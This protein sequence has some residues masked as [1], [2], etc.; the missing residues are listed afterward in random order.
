[1]CYSP[2]RYAWDLQEQYLK[3]T[4]LN[5]GIRG[6]VVRSI[7]NRIRIW[8][9]NTV[10][11]VNH[12]I[13]ISEY[14]SKRIKK[15]YM[16][17]STV[18]YPPVDTEKFSLSK[19]I[20]KEYYVTCSRM[21][22]YK[23]IDL[24]VETFTKKFPDKK[25][26]VVGDGPDYKKIK[27]LAG[28]NILF[29][30][31]ANFRVLNKHLCHAKAFVFAAEEDF[32]ISPIEAQSCGTPVIAFGKGGAKETV[33]G[34]D[35]KNPTGVF[36]NEQTI[37]S[38]SKAIHIFEENIGKITRESCRKNALRFNKERFRCE[39]RDFVESKLTSKLKK[40]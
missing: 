21:V 17:D 11:S 33:R 12:F 18:I 2:I 8:D 3:E 26:I 35:Q 19:C 9:L 37:D 30:G 13:A 14:I 40:I 4:K 29:E 20:K 24:I 32:G 16:R 6:L 36:F 22:P 23:K 28:L 10:K 34:L 38:L 5:K 31:R 7:L 1:M 25:L 39:F 15:T 27:S